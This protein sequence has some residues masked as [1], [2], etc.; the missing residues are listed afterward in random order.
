MRLNGGRGAVTVNPFPV[1]PDATN[2]IRTWY[3]RVTRCDAEMPAVCSSTTERSS[4]R[5]LV[6][7][8]VCVIRCLSVR[9]S[10]CKEVTRD[11]IGLNVHQRPHRTLTPT[12]RKQ[13]MAHGAPGRVATSSCRLLPYLAIDMGA[14]LGHKR[15]H[16]RRL[17]SELLVRNPGSRTDRRHASCGAPKRAV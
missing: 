7:R 16:L 17:H 4:S 8:S 15:I 1:R 5:L 6:R 2:V 11:G 14:D 12:R 13:H 3:Q 9:G 10:T